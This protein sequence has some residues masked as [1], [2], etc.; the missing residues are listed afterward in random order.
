[1][2]FIS[3]EGEYGKLTTCANDGCIIISRS[4]SSS[5]G[6]IKTLLMTFIMCC[7]SVEYGMEEIPCPMYRF[8]VEFLSKSSRSR[9]SHRC[10]REDGAPPGLSNILG[11]ADWPFSWTN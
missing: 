7:C 10:H 3:R 6:G 5:S 4:G 8:Y 1:M 2:V 9:E 11:L